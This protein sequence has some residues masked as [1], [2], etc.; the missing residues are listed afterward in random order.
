MNT[1]L[2]QELVK[3]NRLLVLMKEMLEELQKALIGEVVMSEE[4]DAAAVALFDNAVPSAWAP[5]IGFLSLKPL[6]SWINDL[7]D[8]IAFLSKWVDSG[9]PATFWISGFFFP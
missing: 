6:A 4:L 5:N 8:R 1:V 3:Y 9:A 7:N 2:T